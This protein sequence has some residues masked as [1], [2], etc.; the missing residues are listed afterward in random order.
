MRPARVG[1]EVGLTFDTVRQVVEGDVIRTASGRSYL[2]SGVRR[3]NTGRYVGRWHLRC[4]VIRP[5]DV[6]DDAV[7]HGLNWYPRERR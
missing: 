2:V 6:P 1:A 5:E 4:V 3:Q 7:V